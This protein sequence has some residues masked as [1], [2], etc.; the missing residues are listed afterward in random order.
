MFNK[1][2]SKGKQ[3]KCIEYNIAIDNYLREHL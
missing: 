3:I 1:P 2:K